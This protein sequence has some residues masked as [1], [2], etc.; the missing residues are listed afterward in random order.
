MFMFF[1]L[2]YPI[3]CAVD[4]VSEPTLIAARGARG[5]CSIRVWWC[6]GHYIVSVFECLWESGSLGVVRLEVWG[7]QT[8]GCGSE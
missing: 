8:S 6:K 5:D 4:F 1:L 2:R 7:Q 3:R